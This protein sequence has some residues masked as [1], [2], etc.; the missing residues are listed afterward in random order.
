MPLF[1]LLQKIHPHQT[2]FD[3]D[4]IDVNV[5]ESITVKFKI[6]EYQTV[7][8]VYPKESTLQYILNDISDKFQLHSKYLKL[9]H[10]SLPIPLHFKLFELC[11]NEY[12]IIDFELVLSELA[13]QFNENVS[14]ESDR[15]QLDCNVYY[16][17]VV[18]CKMQIHNNIYWRID[19]KKIET[20]QKIPQIPHGD[21]I[22]ALG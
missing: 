2:M 16:R 3:L 5:N 13:F 15:I 14:N 11:H 8:Q 12:Q 7:A 1:L 10:Y 22:V 6:N 19:K 4:E 18:K 17:W 20:K 21:I 9:K